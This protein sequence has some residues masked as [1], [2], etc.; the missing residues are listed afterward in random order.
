[1]PAP[2]TQRRVATYTIFTK[3]ASVVSDHLVLRL[4]PAGPT[5]NC[6]HVERVLYERVSLKLGRQVKSPMEKAAAA[7][8]AASASA[9]TTTTT[10]ATALTLGGRPSTSNAQ[11]S[12]PAS[13]VSPLDQARAF[14]LGSVAAQ[15]KE[16]ATSPTSPT[17][18]IGA[19]P[20]AASSTVAAGS[21]DATSPLAKSRPALPEKHAEPVWFKSKVVS[22]THAEIWLK[23]GQVYLKDIGS[24]S[25]TFLNKMRLSPAG[26]LSRPYPIR[27]G[28][29][30][31]LGVDYQGRSEDIYKAVEMK[32][33]IEHPQTMTTIN[34]RHKASLRFR[35]ALRALLTATNPYSTSHASTAAVA[36][37]SATALSKTA[38]STALGSA[39]GDDSHKH[40][41]GSVDCCICLSSIGPFQALFIAPCSHCFHYKCIRHV[42]KESLMFPCPV[43]RQVAN[44]DASVSMESLFDI[45]DNAVPYSSLGRPKSAAVDNDDDDDEEDDGEDDDE[46]AEADVELD[47]DAEEQGDQRSSM[48]AH[49]GDAGRNASSI[50]RSMLCRANQN[51]GDHLSQDNPHLSGMMDVDHQDDASDGMS[52]SQTQK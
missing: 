42:L 36:S 38:S 4:L 7:A 9:T 46:N 23:D 26:K 24:S 44:L 25:G 35:A 33:E 43:C 49:T 20:A 29:V 16:P 8:A 13:P 1:M 41:G 12:Q 50:D 28:D 2:G 27:Q 52:V 30:I 19:S 14:F 39:G 10:A 3:M 31:Q 5:P 34:K 32:V 40:H 11:Q 47:D 37:A 17:T 22:R 48:D 18:A 51:Q 45:D 15:L 21:D 6:E